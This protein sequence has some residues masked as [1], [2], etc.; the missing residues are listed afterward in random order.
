[1]SILERHVVVEAEE[2]S[3]ADMRK[4]CRGKRYVTMKLR[5]ERLSCMNVTVSSGYTTS[6]SNFVTLR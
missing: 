1:M 5:N 4:G 6:Y 3:L 2:T